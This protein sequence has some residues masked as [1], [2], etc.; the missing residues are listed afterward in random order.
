MLQ[1]FSYIAK[2]KSAKSVRGSIEASSQ[3]EAIRLLQAQG[4][5][6]N[7]IRQL[8][9]GRSLDELREIE[10]R[11]LQEVIQS[12]TRGFE[13]FE[14]ESW[15]ITPLDQEYLLVSRRGRRPSAELRERLLAAL[16]P[17][18]EVLL[19]SERRR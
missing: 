16:N 11:G 6:L 18:G 2:D 13:T 8:L 1:N 17:R 9:F 3:K 10:R 14:S 19:S 5:P 7:R 4:L 15:S 12:P